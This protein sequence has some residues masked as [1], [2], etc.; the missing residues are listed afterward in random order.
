MKAKKVKAKKEAE[1]SS[2]FFRNL[3]PKFLDWEPPTEEEKASQVQARKVAKE[4]ELKRVTALAKE[5]DVEKEAARRRY[6][7]QA[8]GN[9]QR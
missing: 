3:R 5:R 6:R 1:S 7:G 9:K 2:V 4:D 8:A